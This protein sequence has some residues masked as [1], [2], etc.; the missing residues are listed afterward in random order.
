MELTSRMK[1]EIFQTFWIQMQKNKPLNESR[2]TG[3][4][5]RTKMAFYSNEIYTFQIHVKYLTS[6]DDSG[7]HTQNNP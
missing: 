3:Q 4:T 6:K 7:S 1:M 5:S 2:K